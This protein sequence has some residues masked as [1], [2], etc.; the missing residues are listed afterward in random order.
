[1]NA[2]IAIGLGF[3]PIHLGI[4]PFFRPGS[5]D[6]GRRVAEV[7]VQS[8]LL[9]MLPPPGAEVWR[10]RGRPDNLSPRQALVEVARWSDAP[11]RTAEQAIRALRS[12]AFRAQ[13]ENLTARPASRVRAAAA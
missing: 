3:D 6:Q 8:G 13:K 1:M 2:A 11:G 9:D 7:V 12:A 10:R 4:G 5:T